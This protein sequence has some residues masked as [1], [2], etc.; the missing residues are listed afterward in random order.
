MHWSAKRVARILP[1]AIAAE[2]ASAFGQGASG[3]DV[4]ASNAQL[5][6]FG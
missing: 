6:R 2:D 4:D 3:R 1:S 5:K